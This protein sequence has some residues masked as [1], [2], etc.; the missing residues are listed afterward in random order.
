MRKFSFFLVILLLV[1]IVSLVFVVQNDSTRVDLNFLFW[2]LP[3]ISLGLLS[4][5]LFLA[6]LVS[7]WLITLM[8]Y[9]ANTL[10]TRR[11]ISEKDNLIK[12][13]EQEKETLKKQLEEK[14]NELQKKVKDLE[15]QP[16]STPPPEKKTEDK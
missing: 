9:I 11:K 8:I 5:L 14:I 10:R 1:L 15:S 3:Q 4:I 6:G 7:M 12:S 13:L 16:V 2:S